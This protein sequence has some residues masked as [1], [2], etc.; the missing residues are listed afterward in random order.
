MSFSKRF[1]EQQTMMDAPESHLNNLNRLVS[2]AYRIACDE[3]PDYE[4][5]DNIARALHKAR[6]EL[7]NLA[8]SIGVV[9]GKAA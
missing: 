6:Q 3:A 2:Y 8:K 1:Y 4:T 5:L 7:N 9:D